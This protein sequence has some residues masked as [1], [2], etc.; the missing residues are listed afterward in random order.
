[1]LFGLPNA[2]TTFQQYVKNTLCP[3]LQVFCTVYLDDILI[4]SQTLEEHI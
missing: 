2:L 4:Y 1:M 3:Y